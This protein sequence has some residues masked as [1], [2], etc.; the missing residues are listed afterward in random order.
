MQTPA[1]YIER[2]ARY[3]ARL[4]LLRRQYNRLALVRLGSF[5]AA[6]LS[7][8]WLWQ[9]GLWQVAAGLLGWAVLF[10][11]LVI[12]HRTLQQ[13][14]AHTALIF[15]INEEEAQ[16][17]QGDFS[18]FS[19]GRTF[20]DSLHPYSGDLDLFGPHSLFQ[21]LNRCTTPEG[22][23]AL[24]HY[25]RK[26]ASYDEVSLRQQA[27]RELG[28]LT[29]WR[30]H[31]RAYGLH[32]CVAS[33][34]VARLMQWLEEPPVFVQRKQAAWWLALIPLA[35][36]SALAVSLWYRNPWWVQLLCV[37]P[38]GLIL[39]RFEVRIRSVHAQTLQIRGMLATYAALIRQVETQPFEST[40]LRRLQ[41]SIRT[42]TLPA[43]A[44][45]RQLGYLLHQ[46]E[47]RNNPFAIFLNLLGLWDLQWVFRLE[48][49]KAVWRLAVS[50]WIGAIAEIEALAALGNLHFNQPDWVFPNYAPYSSLHAKGA[51]HPLLPSGKRID[52]DL[53]MPIRGH[54]K[55]LTG[56]NMAGK[57]TF[58]RTIGVNLVLA[59][60]GAPVCARSFTCSRVQVF[61]SM[62]TQDAL[63]ENASSFYAELSRL[64][65]LLLAVRK[66]SATNDEAVFFLL[67]E[68]LKGTNSHDRY[69]G[70]EAL[71]RQLLR[72]QGAGIIATH[73]LELTR[74]EPESAGHIE[75][76]CMDVQ[77]RDGQLVFD[78][79][80]RKGSSQTFNAA[81]LMREIGIE[82]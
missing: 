8:A 29:D 68:I 48:R 20:Q 67:D 80:V 54:I 72:L 56:S 78:Y 39:R 25:L 42:D 62:R 19:D 17:C 3:Q 4:T 82:L 69:I 58:L 81:H 23:A 10:T 65:S 75:N 16:A 52:N 33:D 37:V 40:L 1:F 61:S 41:Q 46:L 2:S 55:L 6:I 36:L 77:F 43:S 63:S 73:D 53:D 74:L 5:L 79:T 21:L 12:Y 70:A 34:D 49:W 66:A 30:Q 47:V 64:R 76:L 14:Q 71:I 26:A 28:T 22:Q 45:L 60:C 9:W 38:A 51:G 57:S 7:V 18:C 31:F 59:Q 27:V 44:A 35:T 32:A 13:E 24:A 11:R 50:N 15:Q